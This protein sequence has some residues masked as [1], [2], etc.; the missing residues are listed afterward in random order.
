MLPNVYISTSAFKNRSLKKIFYTCL[1][2]GFTN[3]ELSA[4]VDYAD[5][6][7]AVVRKLYKSGQMRFLVHNYFP[8]PKEDFVLNLA[9]DDKE[10]VR[11]SVQH[12]QIALDLSADLGAPFFSVHAG[13]AFHAQPQDLGR[14]QIDL[15]RISYPTAYK[16]FV[17]NVRVLLDYAAKRNIQLAVENNV[18][19]K[20]NLIKGKNEIAL[21]ADADEAVRFYKE[22]GRANL[23]FLIDLGHLKVS[24]AAMGFGR[25]DYLQKVLPW[26]AAFHLSDNDGLEDT[27]RPFGEDVWFKDVIKRNKNKT[28][29]LEISNVDARE[30]KDCCK[31]L[32]NFLSR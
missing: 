10:V 29:I 16:N 27:T 24:S 13:F 18:V 30:I 5:D 1:E 19:A 15:P 14:P 12:C 26:A 20:F 11:R 2:L 6:N 32:E 25:E 22:V 28:W 8:R 4:N 17:K 21:L 7:V 9:S 23:F 31:V 3:V